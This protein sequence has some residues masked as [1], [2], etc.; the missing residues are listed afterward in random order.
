MKDEKIYRGDIYL[1]NLNPYKGSEQGGKR[2]VIIIQ[3]DVGNRYSPT[4]IVTAVTSRFF[5]K[6]A[7]PTHVPLDNE[8][9]EKNSLA[10]LEQIRTI[11]KSRLI[12]KIGRVPEEKMK[13]IGAAINVSLDLNDENEQHIDASG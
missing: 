1:A 9:L 12:R 5:K 13:E 10:L 2:P 8:E 6:R 3:N 7:L 11:D 4:V